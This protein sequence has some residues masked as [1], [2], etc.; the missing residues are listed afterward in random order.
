M[1]KRLNFKALKNIK[2]PENA[3]FIL[4]FSIPILIMLGI[5]VAREIY[6]FGE[7]CFLRTDM[8]HQYAP[9]FSEFY[10]KLKNSGSLTYS[11]NIGMG[12]NFTALYAYYLASPINWLIFLSPKQNIIEFMSIVIILKIALSS[13]T[14][15][16][17]LSKHFNTKNICIAVFSLFYGL[18][19]YIAAYSWN[20]MW[21]DCILLLP[22][23][24]LGLERLVNENKCLMYCLS[25]G[26]SILSNYYISIMIC[27]FLIPYFFILIFTFK[28]REMKSHN[29]KK[30]INFGVFSLLAGGFAAVLILPEFFALQ[31]TASGDINFPNKLSTYFTLYDVATRHLMNVETSVLSGNFPNVY[32]GLAV[33]ILFPLY[34]IN[35][36]INTK[37]KI[38]K[39]VLLIVFVISFNMNIPN[40]IWHGFH[41]PNSL[42]CRQ[43]FIYIFIM[44]IMCYEGFQGI[45]YYSNKEIYGVFWGVIIFILITEKIVDKFDFSIIYLSILFICIYML[46][47][48]LYRNKKLRIQIILIMLFVITIAETSINMGV[49]S[50]STTNRNT[51]T[52]DNSAITELT[53]EIMEKDKD[54]YRIEKLDRRTKNDTAWH[55]I[56]G[57][58]VFSSTSNEPLTKL[59]GNLGFANSTNAYSYDGATPLTSAILSVKYLLNKKPMTD[60]DLIELYNSKDDVSVYKNNYSLPLGFMVNNKIM[61]LATQ[62][63]NPFVMQNDFIDKAVNQSSIFSSLST[64][65]DYDTVEIINNKTQRVYMYIQSTDIEKIHVTYDNSTNEY[66]LD[67]K[68]QIVDLGLCNAGKSIKVKNDANSVLKISAYSFD[69][70]SFKTAYNE[71]N[72]NPFII[73]SFNDTNITGHV[74]AYEDGI[75]FTSIPYEKGWSIKV[76]SIETEAIKFKDALIAIDISE[77]EHIITFNY[78]PLGLKLGMIISISSIIILAI[79]FCYNYIKNVYYF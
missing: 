2:F 11:W 54:F 62:S 33:C 50:V 47:I 23:I 59:L 46:L 44:L 65:S 64:D 52:S 79:F 7:N 49:T 37:E 61:D 40:F 75:L 8:Y 38:F 20:I 6:P 28:K 32:S 43:S 69:E 29:L 60:S 71:L 66:D 30:F 35:K 36:S 45:R 73:D 21:L 3:V 77:G 24:V 16:I 26:V 78:E 17:Y 57:V 41:F 42:P 19:S 15:S 9:F 68:K 14:F 76:D 22:I 56:R 1:I 31:L 70:E 34:I 25:L 48:Y 27:I 18:S 5:Y 10:Y 72:K 39:I 67:K 74:N 58:S 51:Y 12:T 53:N 4:S 55:N 13:L 63:N